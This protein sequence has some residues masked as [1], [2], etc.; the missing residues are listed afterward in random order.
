MARKFEVRKVFL[1]V[2]VGMVGTVGL[3]IAAAWFRPTPVLILPTAEH[4]DCL[5]PAEDREVLIGL[6]VSG[7]GSRAALFAAGAMEALAKIRV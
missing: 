1:Y 4:P 3:L 7:G 6:G 2:V 5:T